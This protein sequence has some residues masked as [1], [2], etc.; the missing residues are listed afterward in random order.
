MGTA[1]ALLL[2]LGAIHVHLAA[3]DPPP[4]GGDPDI[5]SRLQ[6]S[7]DS[8]V[9]KVAP[10]VVAIHAEGGPQ[11]GDDIDGARSAISSRLRAQTGSGVLIREDGM[12]LTSEHVVHDAVRITVTLSDGRRETASL[13]GADIR[14]DLAIIRV[15]VKGLPAAEL[16][17]VAGVR[18]G[19]IVLA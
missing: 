14:S 10:C 13:V 8:L 18:R 6:E 15:Q 3:A 1:V 7:F 5:L 12:I 17:D 11:G 19:H 2:L 16:G 9:A 4:S